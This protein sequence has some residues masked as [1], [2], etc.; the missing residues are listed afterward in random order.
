MI[1]RSKF[2]LEKNRFNRLVLRVDGVIHE[3]VV[4]VRN[5]PIHFSREHISLVNPEGRECLFIQKIDNLP[6]AIQTILE[7]EFQSREFMPTIHQIQSVNTYTTPSTWH[8][9]TDRG[10]TELILKGEEDIRRIGNGRLIITDAQGIQYCIHNLNALDRR[11]LRF[12][13]RFL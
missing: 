6:P 4:P 12:L 2:T 3:G 8:I 1:M 5:F 9:K 11:S 10:A 13:E 7:A